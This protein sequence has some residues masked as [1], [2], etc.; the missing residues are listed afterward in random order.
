[1]KNLPAELWK[2]AYAAEPAFYQRYWV[3]LWLE[4]LDADTH[5]L[6]DLGTT[7]LVQLLE[8]LK[9]TPSTIPVVGKTV[10]NDRTI[11]FLLCEIQ[12]RL[13]DDATLA[14]LLA[15]ERYRALEAAIS[16]LI[17]QG[18]PFFDEHDPSKKQ[19]NRDKRRLVER[20]AQVGLVCNDQIESVLTELREDS[21]YTKLLCG[22]L[23]YWLSHPADARDIQYEK[24]IGALT[25]S[26]QF[27]LVIRQRFSAAFLSEYAAKT[28]LAT[29]HQAG[30]LDR[31]HRFLP[32]LTAQ[33]H[34]F[35]VFMRLQARKELRQVQRVGAIEIAERLPEMISLIERLADSEH[36]ERHCIQPAKQFFF[37]GAQSERMIFAI[38]RRVKAPNMASAAAHSVREL[39]SSLQRARFEFELS[40]F[41]LDNHMYIFNHMLPALEPF[42][43]RQAVP[44]GYGRKGRTGKLNALLGKIEQA[45]LRNDIPSNL[46]EKV[47]NIAVQWHQQAVDAVTPEARF[48]NHWIS[49]EQLLKEVEPYQR[50]TADLVVLALANMLD[51]HHAQSLLVNLWGDLIRCGMTGS[52]PVVSEWTGTVRYTNALNMRLNFR[53]GIV[54][55]RGQPDGAYE[56]LASQSPD[57]MVTSKNSE[58]DKVYRVTD[59]FQ[60]F[61]KDGQ[62]IRAGE[63]ICGPVINN[64]PSMGRLLGPLF[65]DVRPH[66]E[67]VVYILKHCY[68]SIHV[69]EAGMPRLPA[70][71]AFVSDLPP[72][73]LQQVYRFEQQLHHLSANH[74]P[75]RSALNSLDLDLETL[76]AWWRSTPAPLWNNWATANNAWQ[77][78]A[79]YLESLNAP[80]GESEIICICLWNLALQLSRYWCLNS[81]PS[82]I[83]VELYRYQT[84]HWSVLLDSLKNH[85]WRDSLRQVCP[86]QPLLQT[87]ISQV[88]EMIEGNP[89]KA[90]YLW[91][92]DRMRRTRNR[93]VH[94]AEVPIGIEP[95]S[96]RLYQWSRIY[97]TK[98][99]DI[100]AYESCPNAESVLV[101]WS[102]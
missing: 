86:K 80:C 36:L 51:A 4:M 95:L 57:I 87:R 71:S 42:T 28:F 2:E 100:L 20:G 91:E 3:Q 50:S 21:G 97:I 64:E 76:I 29:E 17:A 24:V 26:L 99:L 45:Q 35:D 18:K 74:W 16:R 77:R 5:Y 68:G 9:E 53:T 84:P 7:D 32:N 54:A 11:F 79:S 37:E 83:L 30:F 48:M 13:Q 94:D 49:L 88:Q 23:A 72:E 14:E 90:E 73:Q 93:L 98:V 46:L 12:N 19:P 6:F 62:M 27:D 10:G 22:V 33:V 38:V 59:G 41:S 47:T 69:L 92:L 52:P 56:G 81:L 25:R 31:L 1:M 89:V 96:K 58:V 40:S 60:L 8:E 44:R 101:K 55:A 63:L 65:Q 75:F 39:E 43:K 66:L 61:V 82:G 34:E 85:E 70:I 67:N 78:V 102:C 15:P